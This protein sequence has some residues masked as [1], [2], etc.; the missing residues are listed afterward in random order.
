MSGSTVIYATGGGALSH[1]ERK[2]VSA[3]GDADV[4]EIRIAFHENQLHSSRVA[5]AI[6]LSKASAG[7]AD[8]DQRVEKGKTHG[9]SKS[10]NAIVAGGHQ[11]ASCLR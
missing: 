7:R 9:Q 8:E 6:E 2:V 10:I 4:T 3:K 5:H 11:A 1:R